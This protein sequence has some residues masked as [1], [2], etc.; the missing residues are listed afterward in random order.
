MHTGQ[1]FQ[2]TIILLMGNQ[3]AK[4]C[5]LLT[6]IFNERPPQPRYT[7]IWNVDVVLTYI[8]NN[9]SVNSHLSEKN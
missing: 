5:A 2:H 4:I 6:G 1:L 9:M 3:L 8:K 7:F